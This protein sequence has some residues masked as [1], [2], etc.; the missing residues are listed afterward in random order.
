MISVIITAFKEPRTIGKAVLSFIREMRGKKGEIIVVAPD[1]ETLN[2]AGKFKRRFRNLRLIKDSG[3]GK[4]AALNLSVSRALGD[5][6]V[7]SDGDV[8]IGNN[9]L[10]FILK[11][12]ND[13][14]IGAVSGRPISIN[15]KNNKYGFWSF[16]LTDVADKR[17]KRAFGFGKRF[18]C[19]GYL[20]A[21]RKNLFPKLIE[22]LLSEDGFISH[23]VYEQGF[24]IAYT[25]NALVY[26]KYP[27]NLK[28]WIKQKRRSAGGYNQLR[29][30]LNVEIRSFKKES[31]GILDFIQYIKSFREFIWIVNLFLSRVYLW[32]LIYKDVNIKKKKREELWARVES[33]K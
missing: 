6:L 4:S 8:F 7:F 2:A 21:I 11:E 19:S 23:K 24:R 33:T 22:E 26:V 12:F 16:V 27:S 14:K 9:A 5:I 25:D 31:L 30:L 18:F 3:K 28:D 29:K 32:F 13:E 15:E 10:K 20:F 1:N 17:R